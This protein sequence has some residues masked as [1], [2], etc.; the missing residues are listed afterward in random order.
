MQIKYFVKI[1]IMRVLK[2]AAMDSS[3][4]RAWQ[5]LCQSNS[6]GCKNIWLGNN[7]LKWPRFICLQLFAS[8]YCKHDSILRCWSVSLKYVFIYVYICFPIH[9]LLFVFIFHEYYFI[10]I[11]TINIIY[12]YKLFLSII[13]FNKE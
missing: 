6:S 5:I 12:L 3:N 1:K 11:K 9:V 8:A 4:R 10:W 2:R 13:I 7:K